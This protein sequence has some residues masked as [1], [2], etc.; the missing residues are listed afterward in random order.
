MVSVCVVCLLLI[1][2][3]DFS[4][5]YSDE[6]KVV[7]WLKTALLWNDNRLTW[8]PSR[9]GNVDTIRI[10]IRDIWRPDLFLY[11]K[12]VN[13]FF[14]HMELSNQVN[15]EAMA[16]VSYDG[17]VLWVPTAKMTV[18]AKRQT[19]WI[20]YGDK[21]VASFK[22]GS[23]TYDGFKLDVAFFD[24]RTSM[25]MDDYISQ[26]SFE[27]VENSAVKNVKKYPC[28]DEPYPDLTFTLAF[29][30]L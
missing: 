24:N 19:S 17:T 22:Y 9:F 12:Q 5:A 13:Y 3:L 7:K 15:V 26:D 23:W 30:V 21:Y 4:S 28:C 18:M 11:N 25:V 8:I 20:P 29:K 6:T 14:N 2:Q 16:V 1:F 27:I 10:P